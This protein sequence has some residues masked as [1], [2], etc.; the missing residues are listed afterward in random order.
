MIKRSNWLLYGLVGISLGIH[1]VIFMHIA[2]LYRSDAVTYIELTLQDVTKH[3]KRAIPRPHYRPRTP[4]Q[5]QDKKRLKITQRP[6]P[7]LKPIQMEPVEMDLPK[8]L[9]EKIGMP[10]IPDV[11]RLDIA[12]W[13][14]GELDRA[15][16]EYTSPK[17]YLEM[18][19]LRIESHKR[20]P[21]IARIRQREGRV[22]IRFII[23]PEG[24]IMTPKVVKTSRYKVLDIAALKAV[25]D[26]APFPKPP[27]RFFKG[28]IPLELT[29]V[30]EL[31]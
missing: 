24:H 28:E 19:R 15:S 27:S 25:K 20:Y 29:V 16:E 31:T 21:D 18:V 26:A 9:V 14:P 13:G 4:D 8:G 10:A 12:D 17:G 6:I 5:Y 1:L 2:Q 3:P 22:T 23:T 30:F 11:L 7:S